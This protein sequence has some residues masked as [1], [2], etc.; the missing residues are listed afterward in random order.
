M[1][2]R[3]SRGIVDRSKNAAWPSYS[4]HSEPDYL[5]RMLSNLPILP[6]QEMLNDGPMI[7]LQSSTGGSVGEAVGKV[8]V[9]SAV[10]EWV[11]RIM[12]L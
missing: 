10:R 12:Q 5:L 4:D 11:Q 6:D 9:L 2:P 1:F 3:F 8:V 7:S